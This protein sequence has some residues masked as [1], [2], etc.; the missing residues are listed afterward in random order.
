[1]RSVKKNTGWTGKGFHSSRP[2]GLLRS[3]PHAVRGKGI[4][5]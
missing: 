3:G 5:R 4:P 1:V 2:E